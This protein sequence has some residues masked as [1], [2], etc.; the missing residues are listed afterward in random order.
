MLENFAL[1]FSYFIL[2]NVE[3]GIDRLSKCR[4]YTRH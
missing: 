2:K 3:M 1:L 4:I